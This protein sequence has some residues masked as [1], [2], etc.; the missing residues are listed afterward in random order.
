MF[1]GLGWLNGIVSPHY[2]ER[3]ADFDPIVAECFEKA[4]GIENDAA[5]V[6]EEGELT[7]VLSSGGNVYVLSGGN[8]RIQKTKLN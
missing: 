2:N 7:E 6:F 4:Y 8:G 3:T 1:K 5:M